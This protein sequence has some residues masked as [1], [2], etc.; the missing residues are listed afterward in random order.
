M[1]KLS[2][3]PDAG[4]D[5][6]KGGRRRRDLPEISVWAYSEELYDCH[7]R[8]ME[9]YLKQKTCFRF[10]D[11][12]GLTRTSAFLCI[13]GK[14]SEFPVIQKRS[15]RIALRRIGIMPLMRPATGG[16]SCKAGF[17]F[18]LIVVNYKSILT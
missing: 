9:S 13:T 6:G 2:D 4:E 18:I 15:A 16:E 11:F 14:F 3:A 10:P 5:S 8:W 12:K 1:S 7:P 17:F